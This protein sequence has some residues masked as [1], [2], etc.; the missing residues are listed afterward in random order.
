MRRFE[1]DRFGSQGVI[2][3]PPSGKLRSFAKAPQGRIQLR[4]YAGH[5]LH[6]RQL[7]RP[8]RIAHLTDQHVG[9]VTARAVQFAA[10]DLANA[11]RP[12]LVLLTGD[13]VCHGH[14]YLDQLLEVLR[15][16]EAPTVGVLGNHDHWSGAAAVGE[17][18]AD[19]G[20]LLLDNACQTLEFGRARLQ[21]V[22]V[23][24][25][26]TGHADLARALVGFDPDLPTIGLS[27]IAEEADAMW[28]AGVPLVLSGHTHAGQVTLA[29]FNELVIGRLAGRRYIHGMYGSR[30]A[31]RPHGA[32]YVGAGIGA[33]VVPV[34][35]GS[36][37]KREVAI[38]ELGVTPGGMPESGVERRAHPVRSQPARRLAKRAARVV[39][40]HL[41][42]DSAGREGPNG[43]STRD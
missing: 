27:H 29:G 38:F 6:A 14:A 39:R 16:I 21:L 25:A 24:D 1:R 15:R 34:R 23:D 40:N 37:A 7:A 22:G 11:E 19:A 41:R 17:V 31:A 4:R 32:V 33:A 13:F 2:M 35:I 8:L 20:V 30:Q 42:G 3:S 12:D 28:A 26:Y 36:R 10:V 18:L 43:K 5:A 9:R